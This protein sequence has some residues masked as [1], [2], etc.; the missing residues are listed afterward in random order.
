[1]KRSLAIILLACSP[2]L[3]TAQSYRSTVNSGNEAY[4]QNKFDEA[5]KK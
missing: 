2:A 1:M 4:K 3:L 5:E